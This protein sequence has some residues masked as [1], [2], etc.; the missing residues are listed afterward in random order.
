MKKLTWRVTSADGEAMSYGSSKG[1][2]MPY[3]RECHAAGA[4]LVRLQRL[5][6]DG[7][8]W[9]DN[10]TPPTLTERAVAVVEAAMVYQETKGVCVWCRFFYMQDEHDADCPLVEQGFINQDGTRKE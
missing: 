7:F 2:L 5:D 4:T 10:G 3:V 8:S 6:A 9:I 1:E